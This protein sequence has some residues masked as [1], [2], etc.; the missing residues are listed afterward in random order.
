MPCR[1][2]PLCVLPCGLCCR[3]GGPMAMCDAQGRVRGDEAGPAEPHRR[4]MGARGRWTQDS[5]SE[6]RAR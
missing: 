6:A 3:C 4:R 2:V 1:V 5:G